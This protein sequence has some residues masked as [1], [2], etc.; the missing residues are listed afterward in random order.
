[1][2]QTTVVPAGIEISAGLN[3]NPLRSILTVVGAELAAV[4][5]TAAAVVL[6]TG[7][8]VGVLSPQAAITR[9]RH[10]IAISGRLIF[11][12]ANLRESTLKKSILFLLDLPLVTA[13]WLY[14]PDDITL[15]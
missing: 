13:S 12:K 7:T 6:A 3:L 1:L 10:N 11:P 4:T 8:W 2:V 14:F 15:F 9:L 5:W